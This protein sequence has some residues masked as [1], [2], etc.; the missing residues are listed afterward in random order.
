[1]KSKKNN[2]TQSKI[3]SILDQ[4]YKVIINVCKIYE[5]QIKFVIQVLLKKPIYQIWLV[6][7]LF[8]VCWAQPK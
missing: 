2:Y 5:K 3:M 8:K 7:K 1:M 4:Q 6:S